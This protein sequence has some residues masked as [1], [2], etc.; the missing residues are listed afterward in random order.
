MKSQLDV[1]NGG[2]IN[3]KLRNLHELEEKIH[4]SKHHIQKLKK[5][6]QNALRLNSTLNEKITILHKESHETTLRQDHIIWLDDVFDALNNLRSNEAKLRKTLSDKEKRI[7]DF[8]LQ[9]AFLLQQVEYYKTRCLSKNLSSNLIKRS[10]FNTSKKENKV[11]KVLEPNRD[12]VSPTTLKV[13]ELNEPQLL[14]IEQL[15]NLEMMHAKILRLNT[16]RYEQ[17]LLMYRLQLDYKVILEKWVSQDRT[18]PIHNVS[19]LNNVKRGSWIKLVWKWLMNDYHL[20]ENEKTVDLSNTIKDLQS[21]L[22]SYEELLLSMNSNFERFNQNEQ[23]YTTEIAALKE[24]LLA[25][26]EN[27]K[28]NLEISDKLKSEVLMVSE[29]NSLLKDK[30]IELELQAEQYKLELEQLRRKGREK[31]QQFNQSNKI[32]KDQTKNN[33]EMLKKA[34]QS[35]NGPI[36]GLARESKK[37]AKPSAV[38]KSQMNNLKR[39]L[40]QANSSINTKIDLMKKFYPQASNQGSIFNPFKY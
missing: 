12:T 25:L 35:Q 7:K 26:T 2:T 13:R 29:Q 5:S 6:L 34:N 33:L 17:Y 4:S 37:T 22:S 27:E 30:T 36:S 18:M 8:K 3:K 24:Q 23:L 16:Y 10:T 14:I 19:E 40:T 1:D 9:K 21:R 38:Q 39:P 20:E 28:R 32:N 11:E 31:F 15:N